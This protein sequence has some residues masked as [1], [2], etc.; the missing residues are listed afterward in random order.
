MGDNKI[1][2][3]LKRIEKKEKV[4]TWNVP[5]KLDDSGRI[6]KWRKSHPRS[7]DMA[8]G[9]MLSTLILASKSKKILEL[10]CSSGYSTLWMSSAIKKTKWHIYT[11]ES[12]RE[13]V[14]TAKANFKDAGTEKIITLIEGDILKILSKWKNGKL[15][16]IFIDA[17]KNQY[18]DYYKL[19]ITLLKK[20]GIIVADNI[21]SHSTEIK[22]FLKYI[23]R[24]KRIIF[25][26]LN[27]GSGVLVLYKK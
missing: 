10:G 2:R 26:I 3:V 6:I 18:L 23:N 15:D 5:D 12:F 11:T 24:D 4:F 22:S 17:D 27:I 20:H 14:Q 21:I 1:F 16:F 7:V 25:S 8:T 9:Q 19:S 13:K